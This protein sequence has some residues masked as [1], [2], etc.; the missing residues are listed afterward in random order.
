M[1][2][3]SK[4]TGMLF[5][6]RRLVAEMVICPLKFSMITRAALI[7]ITYILSYLLNIGVSYVLQHC[8]LC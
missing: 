2:G 6:S 1:L 4:V 5:S 7:V 8:F 3:G